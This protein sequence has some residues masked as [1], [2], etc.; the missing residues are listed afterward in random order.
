LVEDYGTIID[1]ELHQEIIERFQKLDIPPFTGFINPQYIPVMEN[2]KIVD[3]NIQYA[4]N[5]QEQMLNYSKNYS[6]LP[7]KND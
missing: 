1:N 4:Q 3:I 2:N 6:F 5:Y 7:S